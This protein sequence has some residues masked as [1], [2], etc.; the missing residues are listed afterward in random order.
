M[1]LNPGPLKDAA[2]WLRYYEQFWSESF[3]SLELFLDR[4]APADS[5]KDTDT[6][7]KN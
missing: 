4:E 2:E 3:E 1:K 7:D 6:D 5:D